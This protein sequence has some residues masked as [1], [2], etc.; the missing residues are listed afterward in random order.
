MMV[1]TYQPY[2]SDHTLPKPLRQR[3]RELILAHAE[4]KDIVDQL[5]TS[6]EYVYKRGAN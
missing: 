4:T 2:L 3:I 6:K 5:K 1:S